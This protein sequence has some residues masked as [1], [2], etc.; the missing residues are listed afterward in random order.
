M[1][2]SDV[3]GAVDT[4]NSGRLLCK[5]RAREIPEDTARSAIL[6][7]RRDSSCSGAKQI[8]TRHE[9]SDMVYQGTVLRPSLRNAVYGD[10]ALAVNLIVF[11][12]VIYADDLNCF[13]DF[14]LRIANVDIAQ[15]MRRCQQELH[16]WGYANQVN[17]DASQKSMH[18]GIARTITMKL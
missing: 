1:Y 4:V 2:C 9:I 14:G 5:L 18:S 15:E 10:S 7:V 3:S 13:K 12:E 6:V 11:L 16:K 8:L 17:F